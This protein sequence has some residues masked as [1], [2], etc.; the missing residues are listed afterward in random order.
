MDLTH[1]SAIRYHYQ[2]TT[3]FLLDDKALV[4]FPE[5]SNKDRQDFREIYGGSAFVCRYLHC[6]FSTDGF[7]SPSHRAKH[8]SQHQ[9]RFRCAYSS[10]F[11]FLTGFV[12]RN[13]LNKHNE[14]YHPAIME[15]PSL[16]ESLA[17]PQRAPQSMTAG[18]NPQQPL[19]LQ[20][21]MAAMRQQNQSMTAGISSRQ[22]LIHQQ[23]LAAMRPPRQNQMQQ[24]NNM[25]QN[26]A[27]GQ[28]TEAQIGTNIPGASQAQQITQQ[29]IQDVRNH[30][31]GKMATATDDQ[32]RALLMRNPQAKLT[33]PQQQQQEQRRFMQMQQTRM[34]QANKAR[35]KPME[36]NDARAMKQVQQQ[37][38]QRAVQQQQRQAPVQARLNA[39]A[40]AQQIA[41][42][43]PLQGQPGGLGPGPMLPQPSPA[44]ANL[45][46]P[47][48]TPSQQTN[49]SKQ[50][51]VNPNE[52]GQP[53]DP[54]FTQGRQPGPENGMHTVGINPAMLAGMPP[55]QQ[56]RLINLPPENL[57]GPDFVNF[58]S[59][60]DPPAFFDSRGWNVDVPP[61][62]DYANFSSDVQRPA[63][64][65]APSPE[66]T[67][68]SR[69][70]LVGTHWASEISNYNSQNRDIQPV[71]TSQFSEPVSDTGSVPQ[72]DLRSSSP[73]FTLDNHPVS[74]QRYSPL[75]DTNSMQG[76]LSPITDFAPSSSNK[77]A[78]KVNMRGAENKRYN[79]ELETY[80]ISQFGAP[81]SAYPN[82]LKE[83]NFDK[84]WIDTA[85]DD[86]HKLELLL[87][88][89][90][91]IQ[92]QTASLLPSTHNDSDSWHGSAYPNVLKE[93]NFNKPWIDTALDDKHKLEL[94]LA[95]Q[96]EI[97][98]QIA[99]LLPLTAPPS[100]YQF[101]R[102]PIH[103]QK[104][105]Q[106][107]NVPRSMSSIGTPTMSS[108]PSYSQMFPKFASSPVLDGGPKPQH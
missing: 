80:N 89:Q 39:Q 97:Q 75:N 14:R 2:R 104:Q 15:G 29:Q 38:M 40:K 1:F 79:K 108:I 86:E 12:T 91:Q 11:S 16:A 64:R 20:Q 46:A 76:D 42:Q 102:V 106:S 36:M 23:Q 31:S 101:H 54:R 19:M 84:P 27:P 56:Q 67:S 92:E 94:M 88:K 98:A 58:S 6:V 32:I 77:D 96:A 83:G 100:S 45:N 28:Q 26:I 53:L 82:A 73:S 72:L 69:D 33:L 65:K 74:W 90:A 48:K 49:H 57:P 68:A 71:T 47:L 51:Q 95:K 10:C 8:E 17:L 43:G 85:L 105:R 99:S 59:Q 60:N 50:T 103:K 25:Q 34:G 107:S 66:N 22:Q 93:G 21:Q 87:V 18:M 63:K 9:R 62:P 4:T 81:G 55:E 37:G 5:I 61:E 30:P 70:G 78:L 3:E 7:E 52:F 13:L 24:R 41:L 35:E 44:M